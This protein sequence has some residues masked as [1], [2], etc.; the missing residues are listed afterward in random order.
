[1]WPE[2]RTSPKFN[3]P[4][5]GMIA[6]YAPSSLIASQIASGMFRDV[7]SYEENEWWQDRSLVPVLS[8]CLGGRSRRDQEDQ[9]RRSAQLRRLRQCCRPAWYQHRA[10][11]QHLL[12]VV[13]G[14]SELSRPAGQVLTWLAFWSLNPKGYLVKSKRL[15]S[16]PPPNHTRLLVLSG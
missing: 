3:Q 2:Y 8:I 11:L 7:G 4:T 10:R 12:D 5:L 9:H 1:M 14:T 15:E 16:F 13:V 6:V